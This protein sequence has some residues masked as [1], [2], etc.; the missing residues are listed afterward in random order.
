MELGKSLVIQTRKGSMSTVWVPAFRRG[1]AGT[2]R[3]IQVVLRSTRCRSDADIAERFAKRTTFRG[4][5]INPTLFQPYDPYRP[6]L[7]KNYPGMELAPTIWEVGRRDT[8]PS[9]QLATGFSHRGAWACS[10]SSAAW[11]C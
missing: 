11:V 9:P 1:E 10:A 3:T 8:K 7:Q 5:V 2:A 4:G 6:L